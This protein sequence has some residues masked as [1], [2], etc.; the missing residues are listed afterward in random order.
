MNLTFIINGEETSVKVY[1]E[2]PLESAMYEVLQLTQNNG[3]PVNEWECRDTTGVLLEVTRTP[4]D[5]H[6]AEGARLFLSVRVGAGGT[7]G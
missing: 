6:L 7:N 4:K 3:R 1:D 2:V 5:L